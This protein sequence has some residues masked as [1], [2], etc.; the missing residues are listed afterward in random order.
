LTLVVGD[1]ALPR[2][3]VT[4][5]P[6]FAIIVPFATLTT[7]SRL[8]A[9][10]ETLLTSTNPA[11]QGTQRLFCGQITELKLAAVAVRLTTDTHALTQLDV[12]DL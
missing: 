2:V 10:E 8:E 7:I 3:Q 9:A 11:T 12:T 4:N 1:L 5:K 6:L